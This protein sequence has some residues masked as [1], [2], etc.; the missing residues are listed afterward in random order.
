[1]PT[2]TEPIPKTTAKLKQTDH[3][4]DLLKQTYKENMFKVNE[5]FTGY[6]ISSDLTVEANDLV[7]VIK[8][9]DPCGNPEKWFVDNG[10]K[11]NSKIR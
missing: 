5:Y 8:K 3:I 9:S 7:G 6:G 4:R 11:T 10:C 1:M 2:P